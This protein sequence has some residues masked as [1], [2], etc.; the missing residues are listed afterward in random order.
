MWTQVATALLV[1]IAE[2]AEAVSKEQIDLDAIGKNAG[3]YVASNRKVREA[4]EK[5]EADVATDGLE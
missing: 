4:Q 2:I 3:V 1:A 5:K